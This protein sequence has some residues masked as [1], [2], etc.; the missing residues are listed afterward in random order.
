METYEQCLNLHGHKHKWMAFFDADEFLVIKDRKYH[1]D[2]PIFL[3][4][5]E[6]YA[7]LVV[8]W[9]MYGGSNHL[10]PPRAGES[11]LRYFTK[12]TDETYHG[13]VHVKSIVQ[14]RYTEGSKGNPHSFRYVADRYAVASNFDKVDGPWHEPPIMDRIVLNHYY[15]KTWTE[16]LGK[17]RRGSGDG[18]RKDWPAMVDFETSAVHVCEPAIIKDA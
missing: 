11:A 6:Q 17:I 1:N 13:N 15:S 10:R 18:G 16:V 7:A 8:N 2:L 4:D 12:C 5:Y 14:P 3:E 9:R